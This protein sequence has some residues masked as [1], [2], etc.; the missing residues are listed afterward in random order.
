MKINAGLF[1][2]AGNS[3]LYTSKRMGSE[4]R[5][6]LAKRNKQTCWETLT[7]DFRTCCGP[8]CFEFIY[9]T[10][11]LTGDWGDRP[12]HPSDKLENQQLEARHREMASMEIRRWW[13]FSTLIR[14]T[15]ARTAQTSSMQQI[16][17]RVLPLPIKT[18]THCPT[19]FILLWG[20]PGRGAVSVQLLQSGV[21]SWTPATC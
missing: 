4:T 13:T 6:V 2:E 3:L 14:V 7:A 19:S 21:N 9:R 1:S 8:C 18:L 5:C 12:P 17:N 11:A 10:P 15:A 20:D 16:C